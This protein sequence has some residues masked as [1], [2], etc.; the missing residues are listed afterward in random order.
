MPL[1]LLAY[2]SKL[3]AKWL[4][5]VLVAGGVCYL[6]DLLAAFLLPALAPK[7]HAFIVIPSAIAEISMV[8]YL[9][10]VGVKTGQPP[11]PVPAATGP[12]R[13]AAVIR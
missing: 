9:L 3:F 13:P 12:S 8:L 6:I 10:V 11:E 4:A 2:K 5:V 1:G 7:I